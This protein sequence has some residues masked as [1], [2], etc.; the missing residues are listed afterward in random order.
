MDSKTLSYLLLLMGS[1]GMEVK[2]ENVKLFW[3]H[4]AGEE[5]QDSDEDLI[6]SLVFLYN[7][8]K[9][10]KLPAGSGSVKKGPGDTLQR[11]ETGDGRAG[12]DKEQSSLKNSPMPC[13]VTAENPKIKIGAEPGNAD[14]TPAGRY[15]YGIGLGAKK[16]FK[17]KG[18]EDAEVYLIS[19]KDIAAIVHKCP[20][21]PYQTDDREIAAVWITK[22]QEVL[23]EAMMNFSCL[24]PMGFDVIIDGS[25]VKDPDTVVRSWLKDRYSAI[26]D[27]MKRLS[28]KVEY[29]VKVICAGDVLTSMATKNPEIIEATKRLEGMSKGAS[30]LLRSELDKKIRAAVENLRNS[31]AK[32]IS[33]KLRE[34]VDDLKENKPAKE[35]PNGKMNILNVALLA[36]PAKVEV[37]GEFLEEIQT[38][39]GMEVSFT[40]PWPP[41]N[42]V[43]DLDHS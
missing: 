42:F 28:G 31:M 9:R 1:L 3:R 21:V 33:D 4:V 8:A 27:Q 11:E 25:S 40:G 13:Q 29:G 37:I 16:N 35:N 34:F 10:Q 6:E 32:E 14:L 2:P 22:H 41:Y 39:P 43:K 19:Y 5:C 30:Y 18:I 7:S 17:T 24:I 38:R 12:T 15:I 36:D 23:D 20:T 26:T